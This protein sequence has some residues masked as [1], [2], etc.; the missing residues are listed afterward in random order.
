MSRRSEIERKK[1]LAKAMKSKEKV[2][3]PKPV[4]EKE[5]KK[6]KKKNVVKKDD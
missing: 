3:A 1:E 6:K 2:S 4:V 5:E